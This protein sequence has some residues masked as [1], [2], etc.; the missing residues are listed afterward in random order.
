MCVT[1]C[2][3]GQ[4]HVNMLKTRKKGIIEK[5]TEKSR[6]DLDIYKIRYPQ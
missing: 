5:K 1:A 4:A 6:D 3:D 2:T